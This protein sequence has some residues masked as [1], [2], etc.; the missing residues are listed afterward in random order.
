M[1]ML[2][3]IF[4]GK[5]HPFNLD[6]KDVIKLTG[7]QRREIMFQARNSLVKK[8]F[9]SGFAITAIGSVIYFRLST[10]CFP[11]DIAD[12]I[13]YTL[14]GSACSFL[15]GL[16]S[17]GIG[18]FYSFYR[19]I[20]NGLFDLRYIHI[21]TISNHTSSTNTDNYNSVPSINCYQDTYRYE[22]SIAYNSHQQFLASRPWR[23]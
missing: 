10:G 19:G 18:E 14:L 4:L 16:I 1:N 23:Y 13:G 22:N 3:E 12:I 11:S 21:P 7:E 5:D 6:S 20:C 9:Y 15:G 2:N 8:T 17:I